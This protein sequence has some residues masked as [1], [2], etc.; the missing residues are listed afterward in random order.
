MVSKRV[1]KRSFTQIINFKAILIVTLALACAANANIATFDDMNLPDQSYW[2]GS[3]ESGAFSSGGILFNNNYAY[4]DSYES[5]DGFSYSNINDTLTENQYNAIA[6]TGQGGTSNYAICYI[7]FT[8]LPAITLKAEGIVYGLYVTNNNTAYYSLLN[9]SMFSKKFGGNSGN[10]KDWFMLTITGKDVNDV[11]IGTIEFYLADYR[12]DDNNLDYIVDTWEFIDLSSLGDVKTLEFNL[13]SSDTGIFGMNTPAYF[14]L[15]T[16]ISQSQPEIKG[17]YTES[18]I[19][20]YINPLNNGEHGNPQ[21]ITS[22]INPV[23][24]SWATEVVN[25]YQT[26][27]VDFMWSDPNKALGP[28]T[29]DNMDI[30][31]LGDLSREQVK[32]GEKPGWITLGFSEPFGDVNGYDFVVFENGLISDS[33]TGAGS[34]KGE[35]LAELAFVEV[36]SDGENFIRF[37]SVSL[38]EQ[39]GQLFSTIQPER[40]YNLAGKHV[41]AYGTCTGTPFDLCELAGNPDVVSGIVDINNIMYVRIVDIPG[42]GDFYDNATEH[43]DPNTYPNW[44]SYTN[45]H[46]IFDE[47]NTSLVPQYPSGGFDLEAIGIL[48]EQQYSADIDLNGIVDTNDFILFASAWHTSFGQTGWNGRCDLAEPKDNFIDAYDFD[49]FL[50]HFEQI[51]NWISE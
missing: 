48:H 8:E 39:P 45:N 43:I 19:N 40:V 14:A 7:G 50:E 33:T 32:E 11:I 41:N 6:G 16:I 46:P 49:V 47:W 37:P 4:Y 36:S 3:D 18:G 21:D 44:A 31:S 35:L 12:F 22:E 28:V 17:P 25:Y 10:D 23:F 15:D 42:T 38:I 2:N 51:E 27:G 5:W 34:V 29:G 1:T 13:D 30:F 26:P 24:K 20:G 9:G